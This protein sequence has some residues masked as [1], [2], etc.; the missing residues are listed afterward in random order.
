MKFRAGQLIK[1][2]LSKYE[3]GGY[4][5]VEFARYSECC[6]NSPALARYLGLVT[7]LDERPVM[8][9]AIAHEPFDLDGD[10][11]SR[12]IEILYGD[13]RLIVREERFEAL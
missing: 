12:W 7:V 10:P 9:L 1:R 2:K 13:Q 6:K 11:T 5:P 8:Y 3:E 4:E